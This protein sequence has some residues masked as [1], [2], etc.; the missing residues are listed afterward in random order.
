[1]KNKKSS[2]QHIAKAHDHFFRTAMSDKRVAKEFFESHLPTDLKKRVN[3]NQF[4]LQSGTF[5][6]DL[7]QESIADM[8]FRTVIDHHNAYIYLL[9]DHQSQ[10][11]E[12]MPF[13]VLKYIC[14]VIDQH[15]KTEE[16][17]KIP[18]I[19]PM[20]VYHG[21]QQWKYSTDIND[22]IDA[23]KDLIDSYF[24]KPFTLLDLNK[25]DDETIKQNIWAGVMELTLKHIFK[26]DMLPYLPDIVRIL[27]QLERENG[28]NLIENVLIYILDR[29]EVNQ[30]EFISLIKKE[31]SDETGE[32][33]V[34]VAEQLIAKG[35]ADGIHEE[36][37]IIAKRLLS[38]KLD[39]LFIAKITE[40]SLEQIQ[41]LKDKSH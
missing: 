3:F 11:D 33:I 35:R 7:R 40:L 6:D 17:N 30:D 27:K 24:L 38:E 10:P 36:K 9:V 22:L 14:N 5:I 20:V 12:L 26:R 19:L 18:F 39:E 16:T 28:K 31:F 1:M 25:I 15:L 41:K 13:R 34:T 4:E 32:G 37:V 2:K 8:L 21:N 29:G 23:P